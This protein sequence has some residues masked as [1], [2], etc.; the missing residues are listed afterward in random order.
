MATDRRTP[1]GRTALGHALLALARCAL[2]DD[3]QARAADLLDVPAGAGAARAPRRRSTGSRPQVRREGAPDRGRGA[4][5]R[6]LRDCPRSTRSERA[7]DPR[8]GAARATRGGCSPPRTADRRA[9]LDADEELDAR[10]LGALARALAE[11]DELGDGERLD[12]RRADRAARDARGRRPARRAG[13][14]A[15]LLTDPLAIR[16]RR[17]RAVL[18]CGLGESEF[19]AR[20]RA[21]AVPLGRAP[22]RARHVQRPAAAPAR[23]RARPRALPVLHE[24][25]PGH[26]AGDP[27]LPELGRGGQPRAALAVPRRRGRAARR[28]LA[29][30]PPAPDAR[31]CRV[32]G[33]AGADR[34][35]ARPHAARRRKRRSPARCPR[36][37][38]RCRRRRS[39]TSATAGSCRP[40][41]SRPTPTARSSGSSTASSSPSAS[42]PTPIRS[43]AG[44]TCT[45]CSSRCSSGS[46][47][48]SRRR[49]CRD[50][51]EILDEV[52]A[53]QLARDRRRARRGRARGAA[54][55]IVAADLRRYLAHEARDGCGWPPYGLELRFGFDDDDRTRCRR[56]CSA[57]T[58]ARTCGCA[59]SSTAST[60]TP[61]PA[62]HAVVR[63]YKSGAG[64]PEYH[65]ARWAADRQL[66]V[67]LYMLVVRELLGLEPVGRLLPAARRRRPA[68]PRRVPEGAG[69]AARSSTDDGRDREELDE[70]L[71]DAA[72]ARGGARRAAAQRGARAVPGD[73]LAR[74][75]QRIPGSAVLELEVAD[76]SFTDEQLVA[77]ERRDGDLLLDASAGSGK[78]SVLVER[79]ARSVLEDGIDVG[80]ILTITF[81]EKAAAE[82]RD[83][84]R[85]R[86]RELGADDAA[87]ATEGAFISTIHGFCAR[88]AARP[89]AR[90]RARPGVRRARRPGRRAARRRRL[91]R[92]ARGARPRPARPRST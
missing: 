20:R 54:T 57:R 77:I 67:A 37:S 22:P 23:G 26:R 60:P 87:R 55:R 64:R 79:F 68:R 45:P 41:R 28:G 70:L 61:R 3:G 4:R 12:R 85:R 92:G 62:H 81:T 38:G 10:A 83:R 1:L 72:D 43:P 51:L 18:V 13:A 2:L 71:D 33:G 73:V 48:R 75:M 17:F 24:R 49:R 25:V 14:G 63:D 69:S 58:W 47:R 7:E 59:G 84:I 16:A 32:A 31:R 56:S 52:L 30:A 27:E 82:M 40:A 29:R 66:Q 88:R 53:E 65:G 39:R 50:A 21:R 6:R 11:L 15:V 36:R 9:V 46:A 5:A 19:P 44:A 80:A 34:A 78:T 89:R 76:A 8:D 74:R 90:G 35:R 91:R 42:S 86:L